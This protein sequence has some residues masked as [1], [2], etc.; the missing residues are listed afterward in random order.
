MSWIHRLLK[1]KLTTPDK[2]ATY[3]QGDIWTG[4]A[5]S[6]AYHPAYPVIAAMLPPVNLIGNAIYAGPAPSTR[7]GAQVYV[8]QAS[9]VAGIGGVVNGQMINQ[10]LNIPETTNGSQ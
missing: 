7:Q 1:P 5:E 4:G 3:T 6:A 2:L 10:P 8:N 9:K